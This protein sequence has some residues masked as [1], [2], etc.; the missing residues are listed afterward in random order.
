MGR[1]GKMRGGF[2]ILPFRV[3]IQF[4][5]LE[6]TTPEEYR[7]QFPATYDQ[8]SRWMAGDEGRRCGL[9]LSE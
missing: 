4:S 5:D 3:R 2:D 7:G 9:S 8:L 1:L 6:A